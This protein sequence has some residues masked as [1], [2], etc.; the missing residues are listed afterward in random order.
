MPTSTRLVK[1]GSTLGSNTTVGMRCSDGE[2]H[3]GTGGVAADAQCHIDTVAPEEFSQSPTALRAAAPRCAATLRRQCPSGPPR[4]STRAASRPAAPALLQS[5]VRFPQTRPVFLRSRLLRSFLAPE[6]LPR[7][8]ERRENVP[9]G[10]AA[11]DQQSL[12]AR[13]PVRARTPHVCAHAAITP[14]P[15]AG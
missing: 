13:V 11:G 6:P 4:E 14:G 10:A 8:R 2:K 1:P 9:A 12:R 5:R 15:R 3:H 7:H